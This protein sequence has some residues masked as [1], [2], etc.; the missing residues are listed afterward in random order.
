MRASLFL[1]LLLAAL[2]IS[3]QTSE[4]TDDPSVCAWDAFEAADEE[5][6]A[7]FDQTLDYVT[8]QE[9]EFQPDLAGSAGATL[10]LSQSLWELY[11]DET[12]ALEAY[13]FFGG[14]GAQVTQGQCLERITRERIGALRLVLDAG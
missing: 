5:M 14:S 6:F 10:R 7:L 12:C 2:P 9:A 1:P 4:C 3:A 13:M 11:R 8:A